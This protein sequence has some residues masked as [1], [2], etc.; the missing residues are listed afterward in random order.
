MS[1]R[2][3]LRRRASPRRAP[4]TPRAATLTGWRLAVAVAAL[5]V[6]PATAPGAAMFGCHHHA[7][8]AGA[9]G[10]HEAH[11]GTALPGP[12]AHSAHETRDHASSQAR[13]GHRRAHGSAQ[14]PEERR[15]A[16][17][18][19]QTPDDSRHDGTFPQA[20]AG[21]HHTDTSPQAPDD[22]HR[23]DSDPSC[24]CDGW[25]PT[26]GSPSSPALAEGKDREW[27]WTR[28]TRTAAPSARPAPSR[29]LPYFL[30]LA[31]APPSS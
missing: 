21:H 23:D 22:G 28:V 19:A 1:A 4:K 26:A 14:A 18:S 17:T 10:G 30:P 12:H 20:H 3:R 9:R 7:G 6:V 8:N 16:D 15:R 29:F 31:N 25:C 5:L 13:E 2:T 27:L 24:T 11:R